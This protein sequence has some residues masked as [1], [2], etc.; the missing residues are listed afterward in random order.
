[1][2]TFDPKEAT[3]RAKI[4]VI[5]IGGGGSNAVSYMVRKGL[6]GVLTIA[7]NTDLQALQDKAEAEIKIPI[8]QDLTKGLGAG[9]DPEI[10]KLAMEESREDIKEVI[11]DADMVFL[12]A[13]MGGGTGTGGIPVAAEIA[14]EEGVLTVAV[15]TKPFGF[16]GPARMRKAKEG[17]K[18]LKD[19]VDTLLVIPNDRLLELVDKKTPLVNAFEL[20]D[21]VLYQAVKGIVDIIT[22]VGL[23][24]V[25]FADVKAVMQNSGSAVMGMG[26]AEGE[27]RGIE[28]AKAAI[29]SPLLDGASIKGA[30]WILVSVVAGPDLTLHEINNATGYIMEEVAQD[31]VE[32]E[33]ILGVAQDDSLEGKIQLTVI[34][35][36]IGMRDVAKPKEKIKEEKAAT[37]L[38]SEDIKIPAFIRKAQRNG[39]S[40]SLFDKGSE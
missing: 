29:F 37:P 26:V 21:R 8:G 33:L 11:K 20:A 39:S 40:G 6:K 24:N 28:A 5:G 38:R 4:K 23:V 14:K 13:G 27:D 34:A 15:V 19:K 31:G 1:M 16:E 17:L 9:G 10:G 18:I 7:A 22:R 3:L 2:I 32:P 30:R 36:G 12:T 25:D 35:T